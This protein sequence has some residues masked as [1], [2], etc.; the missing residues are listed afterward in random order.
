[1]YLCKKLRHVLMLVKKKMHFFLSFSSTSGIFSSSKC[2]PVVRLE[3]CSEDWKR[4][5]LDVFV[6]SVLRAHS[7]GSL[8]DRLQTIQNT[9]LQLL[10]L[11]SL[12]LKAWKILIAVKHLYVYIYSFFLSWYYSLL[13]CFSRFFSDPLVVKSVFYWE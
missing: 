11:F 6:S 4:S 13:Y 12:D 5:R 3:R 9:T 2:H 1:M 10:Y 8:L 7:D